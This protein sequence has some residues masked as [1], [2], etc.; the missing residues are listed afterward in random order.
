MQRNSTNAEMKPSVVK[1]EMHSEGQESM[2]QERQTWRS[3]QAKAQST[4][5]LQ[6]RCAKTETRK[7]RKNV[8]KRVVSLPTLPIAITQ[9]KQTTA[10]G[11]KKQNADAKKCR[12]PTPAN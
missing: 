2:K 10:M 11:R 8:R 12:K 7:E 5:E 1:P 6:N 3:R 4:T 9:N